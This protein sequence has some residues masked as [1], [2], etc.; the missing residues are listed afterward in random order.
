MKR[1]HRQVRTEPKHGFFIL[2]LN[3]KLV[4]VKAYR[5]S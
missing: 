4:K 5:N 2:D 1:F 3:W